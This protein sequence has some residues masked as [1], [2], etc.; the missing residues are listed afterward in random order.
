MQNLSVDYEI[1][2]I[3]LII[4]A[5][6]IIGLIIVRIFLASNTRPAMLQYEGVVAPFF[7][8]PAILFSLTAALMA[9]SIWKILKR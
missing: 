9:T 2:L 7:G 5:F 4:M 3:A 6:S 8:L 1:G